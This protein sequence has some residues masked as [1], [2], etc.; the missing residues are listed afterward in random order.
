MTTKRSPAEVQEV[1]EMAKRNLAEFDEAFGANRQ[2]DYL[3]AAL[4]CAGNVVPTLIV[5]LEE[6]MAGRSGGVSYRPLSDEDLGER[7]TPR[8]IKLLD[9]CEYDHVL[10]EQCRRANRLSK[11]LEAYRKVFGEIPMSIRFGASR[12]ARD[13]VDAALRAY[14]G[15][16][17]RD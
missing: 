3:D 7:Y 14:L 1:I 17:G 8:T 4:R 6:L 11:A 13:E 15:D 9:E 16:P 2:R 12:E 10:E 5:V